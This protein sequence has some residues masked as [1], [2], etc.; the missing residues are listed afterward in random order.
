MLFFTRETKCVSLK[1]QPV[2]TANLKM[3][4]STR[5]EFFALSANLVL[6]LS[7]RSHFLETPQT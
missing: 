4:V 7:A 2:Q 3:G 5:L 1:Y 6:A